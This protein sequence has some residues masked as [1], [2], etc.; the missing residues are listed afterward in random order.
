MKKIKLLLILPLIL[1]FAFLFLTSNSFAQQTIGLFFDNSK[2]YV[3]YFLP[4]SNVNTKARVEVLPFTTLVIEPGTFSNTTNVI[5]YKGK[6]Q[7]IKSLLPEKEYPISSYYLLFL[8]SKGKQTFPKKEIAIESYDNYID[9]KAFFY[10]ITKDNKLD[11]ASRIEFKGPVLVKTTLLLD[12]PAFVVATDKVL[13]ENDPSLNPQTNGTK[14]A[15]PQ[16]NQANTPSLKSLILGIIAVILFIV[17]LLYLL[18]KNNSKKPR[19]KIEEPPK[20]IVGGK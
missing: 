19:K 1:V 8:D 9:S 4:S 14:P 20:I 3:H 18:W 7:S 13:T 17:V 16:K 10:G 11:T 5:V 6:W 15:V 12:N 2:P